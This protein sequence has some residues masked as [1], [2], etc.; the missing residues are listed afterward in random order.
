MV[1][2]GLERFNK[3]VDLLGLYVPEESKEILNDPERMEHVPV[4]AYANEECF[5]NND[6]YMLA[7]IDGCVYACLETVEDLE[8]GSGKK[9]F[10]FNG[11]VPA[12]TYTDEMLCMH[13]GELTKA[14]REHSVKKKLMEIQSDF[15]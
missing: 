11:C 1:T 14:Y 2:E 6:G 15:M 5:L 3:I 4:H 9:E 13:L 7:M 10:V 8:T 12:W